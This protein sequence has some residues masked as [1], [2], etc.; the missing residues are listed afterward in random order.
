M[1][2]TS[3]Y[4]VYQRAR[5]SRDEMQEAISRSLPELS[6]VDVKRMYF[7]MYGAGLIKEQGGRS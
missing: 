6:D 1:A 4:E 7:F 3:S 5:Q 2:V